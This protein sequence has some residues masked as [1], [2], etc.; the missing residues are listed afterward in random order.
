MTLPVTLLSASRPMA[1]AF[2][3]HSSRMKRSRGL[4]R[5]AKLLVTLLESPPWMKTLAQPVF[6]MKL[7]WTV[8]PLAMSSR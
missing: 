7:S 1:P 5:T 2:G 8:T 6:W 3:T 4:D